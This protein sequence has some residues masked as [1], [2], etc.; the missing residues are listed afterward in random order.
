MAV[1]L[2]LQGLGV[3]GKRSRHF[4][5][6]GELS[7]TYQAEMLAHQILQNELN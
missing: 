7:A 4:K 2:I 5:Q 3:L 1:L 6:C